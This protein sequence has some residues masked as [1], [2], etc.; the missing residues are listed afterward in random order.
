MQTAGTAT[1]NVVSTGVDDATQVDVHKA[2]AGATNAVSL[3]ALTRD[4]VKP[5]NWS[6][7]LQPVT[8]ADRTD[9]N[10][11]GWYVDVHTPANPA[12]ELRG[13]ITPN[14]APPPP[15]PPPPA[16][17]TLTQLQSTIFTPRCSGCH[18]GSGGSLPG[19]MNLSSTAATF[20]A[21]VGVSSLQQPSLQRVTP[22]DA[23]NSYVVQKLEPGAGISR[24]PLGGPY[25]DQATIDQVKEWINAGAANN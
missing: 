19:S 2:A 21:L 20:A 5:G 25:L 23:A 9:F 13:Q 3:L 14:P 6:A 8:V 7:Q 17:T 4:S 22:N 24:M 1:V 18:N 16:T 15:P 10:N 11:N 12:G